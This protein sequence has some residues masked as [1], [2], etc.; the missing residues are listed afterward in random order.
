MRFEAIRVL[1]TVLRHIAIHIAILMLHGVEP[2]ISVN[3]KPPVLLFSQGSQCRRICAGTVSSFAWIH[4]VVL[5][6]KRKAPKNG[7]S[8]KPSVFRVRHLLTGMLFFFFPFF[9]SVRWRDAFVVKSKMRYFD[10]FVIFLNHRVP[11]FEITTIVSWRGV[12]LSI[13]TLG[14]TN[15]CL[16]SGLDGGH[17]DITTGYGTIF[18]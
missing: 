6:A 13:G 5:K 1:K 2:S 4:Q 9:F 11:T 16:G 15:C 10:A 8:C 17:W 3:Q 7:G 14:T 18:H 12:A